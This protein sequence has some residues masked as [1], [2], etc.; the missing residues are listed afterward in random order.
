MAA[1][2][3]RPLLRPGTKHHQLAKLVAVLAEPMLSPTLVASSG[4]QFIGM[5]FA[6]APFG[7]GL[8]LLG[9]MPVDDNLSELSDEH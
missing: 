6:A 5:L 2:T 8:V 1:S 4:Q 3:A 9:Y 7:L